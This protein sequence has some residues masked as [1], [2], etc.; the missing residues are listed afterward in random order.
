MTSFEDHHYAIIVSHGKRG[1][2][3]HAARGLLRRDAGSPSS[4]PF[5]RRWRVRR[6]AG[7]FGLRQDH[8]A[9][10]GFRLRAGE[11][12]EDLGR[13]TRHHACAAGQAR[14]G[15]GVPVLRTLAAYDHGAEPRLWLEAAPRRQAEHRQARRRDTHHAEIGRLR[16]AQR[17]PALRRAAPARGARPGARHKPGDPASG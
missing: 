16:R 8:A 6:V 13:R 2:R 14:H 1:A 3:Y 9:A 7:T 4:L 15:D 10:R 5:G 12:R 17:D 11:R